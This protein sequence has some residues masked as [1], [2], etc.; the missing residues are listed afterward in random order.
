V[1]RRGHSCPNRTILALSSVVL[2]AALLL[3]AQAPNELESNFRNPPASVRPQ[4]FW[5]WMNGN[6]SREGITLDLEA[7]QRV[8]I[9]GATIFDA[10][11]APEG[12]ARFMSPEWRDLM[13]HAIKEGKRLGIEIG[14]H[15]GPGWSSSGGPWITPERSMQQLVWSETTVTGPGPKEIALPQPRS[16]LGFYRDAMVLAFPAEPGEQSPQRITR[17][18]D[19]IQLE[20]ADPYEASAITVWPAF[21]GR[22]P[23]LT[24]EASRDGSSWQRVTTIS[25]PGRHGIQPPGVRNFPAIKARWFRI[26]GSGAGEM[27]EVRLQHSPRIEDWNFKA[28]FAYRVGRQ[29]EIPPPGPYDY[30]IDPKSVRDLS[31]QTDRDGRLKWDV[32]PG[33]WTLL[34]IGQTTTGQL[35][36]SASDAGRGLECDKMSLEAT[37]FHFQTVIGKVLS[38][39]GPLASVTIDSYEAGMQN[40]TAEFPQEFRK[41]T[42]YDLRSFLPAMT[43]RIVYDRAISERFLFDVRRTQ[44][45]LMAQYYYGGFA[46]AC[47]FLKLKLYV[48]G[49]GQGVFDEMQVSGIPEFP[50]TEFW[51]RT[52]WTPNRVVK[53]VSSAA[54][55]YGKQVVA[56]E[57]FTGEEE[58]ARWLEYPYSLKPLGDL[59]FSLGVNQ[60]VFH[61]YVHQPHPT[62][63]PGM[64][65]GPWGF[66]MDRTNTW[67]E[68]SAAWIKYL[69]RCQ[70]LLRQ[71]TYV[72]DLL[73]FTG[74]RPPG[75]E[76]FEVPAAPAGFSYDLINP[77][78]LLAHGI[79][80]HRIL[81]LPSDLKCVT[82]LLMRQ[83]QAWVNRGLTLVGPK[84][85]C[86]PTLRSYPDSDNE[87]RRIADELWGSGRVASKLDMHMEPDFEYTGRSDTA[88][89]WLHR[90]LPDGDLYFV[91][92][93]Q[94]R[95]EHVTCTFRVAGRA[96]EFWNA[97]TGGIRK[98]TLFSFDGDR[99]HVP[100]HLEPAESV[101]V[102]FHD[103]VSAV[104]VNTIDPFVLSPPRDIKDTFT[105]SLWAKPDIDLRLMPHESTTGHLD[106]TGKFYAIPAD[107][108]DRR[109]GPGHATAGVAIGR[110]GVYV[111]ERSS[112]ASPA[113]L[114]A[115]IPVEG[116]THFAVVYTQGKPSLYVNGAFVREGLKSGSV[117]HPG[118][119][120]PPPTPDTAYHF[121][122]LD[123]L[124][125]ASGRPPQPSN[126]IA[127]YFEGN[128]TEPELNAIA[129]PALPDPPVAEGWHTRPITGPWRVTFQEGRGAP[130][131]ITLPE[132]IS[133]HRHSDPGVRYFS[134]TATYSHRVEIEAGKRVMLDLGRVEVVAEVHVNGK[135]LG[136]LWK[137]PYRIDITEATHPGSNDL[138]IRVTNLWPNRLIGDEQ[139]APENQFA[140][141]SEHGILRLPDW[142]KKGE[143]KPAGGRITFT[144]WQFYKKDDPL[145]ESG[146]L[147][148]V[149]LLIPN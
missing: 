147:G 11:Y 55:V 61:R 103:R 36:V 69:S 145:L 71:G 84:P 56:A 41:R 81:V 104:P 22:F 116:W 117:V 76:N 16:N 64:T 34:R 68:Q 99:T 118:I 85:Q 14:M 30:A 8:G 120:S 26:T 96:P 18:P 144:I 82:P 143:P 21:N 77:D 23:N 124:L 138:E 32:P 49:Y 50:M 74:E 31:T 112:T 137:E 72:S 42:G 127:Y 101:F 113:V 79:G 39:A 133:F 134:G 60:M 37:D 62:A 125:R 43:G 119:G 94:R 19:S 98:A 1:N 12:P 91:A 75:A 45:D 130:A 139:R 141:G 70:Y 115:N 131:S 25:N 89:S 40:W 100:M 108:G 142:Y 67:F 110:N 132:L 51:E 46:G 28:N 44:A 111:V 80:D 121:D 24:L 7:M 52:P 83:L 9:G 123:A 59:M 102:V 97:E 38:Q 47:R 63:V 57:S 87:V 3:T 53:M 48:E 73:Y 4:T 90:K 128:M 149:R 109:F 78:A 146:L 148:P 20:F 105:M 140:T 66:H 29:M 35:N 88:L 129:S 126:G 13:A 114:V 15:N 58:T 136:V 106:E 6:V 93:R 86:S 95:V 122:S 5:P 92:N 33:S 27:A 65:M 54:H 135:D 2:T 10:G 107:E 17:A